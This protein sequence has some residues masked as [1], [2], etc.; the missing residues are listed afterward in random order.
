LKRFKL[1]APNNAG[2]FLQ[3]SQKE[4]PRREFEKYKFAA[5][6]IF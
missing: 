5:K 6:N 2:L 1:K 4:N 3:A